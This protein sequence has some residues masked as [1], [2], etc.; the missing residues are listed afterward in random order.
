MKDLPIGIQTFEKLRKSDYIY[1]D[2]TEQ[3]YNLAKT[4][5]PYFLSRPRRFGKSLLCSTFEVLFEG[6]K[7]LFKNLWI[8]NSNW[9]WQQ[10]P[11]IYL[12]FTAI[13]HSTPKELEQALHETINALAVKNNIPIQASFTLKTKFLTLVKELAQKNPVVLIIDEYDKP[14][15]DHLTNIEVANQMRQILGNFYGTIKALDQYL[16]FVFITGVT[17]FAKISIFS[18]LNNLNDIT[19]D[20]SYSTLC[21]YTFTE[22]KQNFKENINQFA[23]KQQC[24]QEDIISKLTRMYNG[25]RFSDNP[26]KKV[27]N[28]FSI[29]LSLQKN[30]FEDYWFQTG[31]PRFLIDL[32][33]KHNY[34]IIDF[35]GVKLSSSKIKAFEIDNMDIKTLLYQTGY[36]TIADY[37]VES[38]NYTLSYP[39][40]EVRTA[41]TKH[42]V[43]ALTLLPIDEYNDFIK[44]FRIALRNN[45]IEAFCKTLH[46]FFTKIP[47]TIHIEK[48]RYVQ[49]L[50][51]IT[52][53]LLGFEVEVEVATNK[54]R[55]DAVIKTLKH[56][57]IFEFKMKKSSQKAI[58]QIENKKYYQMYEKQGKQITLVG[59]SF[60]VE[61]K[62]IETDWTI[63][64]L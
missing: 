3:I 32:I 35:E 5:T 7:E 18:E 17:K 43:E 40:H 24:S 45:D 39:N 61:K 34:A 38:D 42:I 4:E 10:Y 64:K 21:G 37:D 60:D 1:V 52:A 27:Y 25:Y 22:I 59:I 47:Y 33:K 28:P 58:Q 30:K 2:K 41:L 36:L 9:N 55:I 48:E 12:D 56:I 6:K 62:N 31:T 15:I 46:Q 29:L 16:K 51:T 44:F 19:C 26:D 53:K 49:L 11:I 23:D 50:F 63:K 57:Y 54:G 20:E 13:A 8:E 14:I